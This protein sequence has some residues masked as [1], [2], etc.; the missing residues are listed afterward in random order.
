MVNV[1]KT[2]A[3]IMGVVINNNFV[4]W[5]TAVILERAHYKGLRFDPKHIIYVKQ[6][7]QDIVWLLHHTENVLDE[8]SGEMVEVKKPILFMEYLDNFGLNMKQGENGFVLTAVLP[9]IVCTDPDLVIIRKPD[10][11]I[12]MTEG[13]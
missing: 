7:G 13:Q 8:K 6:D 11:R 1:D 5:A 12:L 9:S 3:T 10:G 2:M 4:E